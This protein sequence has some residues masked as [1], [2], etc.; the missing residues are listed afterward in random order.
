MIS[1]IRNSVLMIILIVSILDISIAAVQEKPKQENWSFDGIFG[2][3]D[4]RAIQRGYQ[5]Y[6]EVC[7]ACHSLSL[8]YYRNL[9]EIGFSKEEV[10]AVAA[11]AQVTDGPNDKGEMF[12]RPG[13]PY[14]KFVSPYPNEEASRAANGG[15]YP[16]DLSLIIK[17]RPDGANY[18]HALLNGYG[19]S[20]PAGITMNDTLYY[21]P[22]FPGMQIAMPQPLFDNAVAY[23][24]GTVATIEQM[25]SDVVNFLQWAAEPE[26]EKRKSMGFKAIIY[27]FIMTIIFYVAKSRIWSKVEKMK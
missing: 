18:I 14:D 6:K 9:E 16:P 24:D 27:L 12:Q 25:S 20:V 15:A 19:Q 1:L 8:L 21:N 3:F 10:A 5:V 2:H 4:Q 7:S 26:M 17:A 22:Y 23:Q 11:E 13:K